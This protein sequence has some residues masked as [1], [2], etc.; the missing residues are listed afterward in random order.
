MLILSAMFANAAGSENGLL[1]VQ[2][3]GFDGFNMMSFPGTV[4]G[5]VAAMVELEAG[6]QPTQIEASVT[7]PDAQTQVFAAQLVED[8]TE[9]NTG[10]RLPL[11]IPFVFVARQAGIYVVQITDENGPLTSLDLDVRLFVPPPPPP[12]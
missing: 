3:G 12:D 10:G 4:H 2:G 1:N 6:H 9:G 7:G 11:V 5:A 8:P